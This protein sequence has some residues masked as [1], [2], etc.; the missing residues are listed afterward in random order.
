MAAPPLAYMS[1]SLHPPE[2]R[3]FLLRICLLFRLV[4]STFTELSVSARL[5]KLICPITDERRMMLF[6]FTRH[7][8]R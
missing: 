3:F 4:E 1:A 7:G 6:L 2:S 5:F 8:G